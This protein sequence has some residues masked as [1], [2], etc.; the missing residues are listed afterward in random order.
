MDI[1]FFKLV[2]LIHNVHL[3]KL[4]IFSVQFYDS[5]TTCTCFF[6]KIFFTHHPAHLPFENH[7]LVLCIWVFTGLVCSFFFF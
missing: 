6:K 1:L 7:Q 3:V 2:L 4:M 5:Y